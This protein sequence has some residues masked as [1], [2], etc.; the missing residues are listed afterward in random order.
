M[1]RTGS[2]A[3]DTRPARSGAASP[4]PRSASR[5]G[6]RAAIDDRR[7]GP[8]HLDRQVVDAERRRPRRARAPPCAPRR[9]L[10]PS[11]VRRSVEHGV[12]DDAPESSASPDDPSGRSAMPLPASRRPERQPARLAE[13][14]PD[15]FERRPARAM[16]RRLSRH[17]RSTMQLSSSLMM[18]GQLEQRAPSRATTRGADA[19]DIP[20]TSRPPARRRRRPTA[21]RSARLSRS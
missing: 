19:P 12:L 2:G 18:S 10:C 3:S 16:V 20:T 14:Q 5:N 8:I 13:V 21:R 11:C 1:T 17:S 9:R 4:A 7:L 15:A 6:A